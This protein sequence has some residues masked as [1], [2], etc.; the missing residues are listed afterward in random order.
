M[1]PEA[2]QHLSRLLAEAGRRI[3]A[4]YRKGQTEHGGFL[5]GY[6]PVE[7]IEFALD[8]AIDQVVYL[9]TLR[10]VFPAQRNAE[11]GEAYRTVGNGAKS[12]TYRYD[13]SNGRPIPV[14]V[15]TFPEQ[16]CHCHIGAK[17]V[18]K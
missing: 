10:E 18:C 1:K 3:D 15:S 14:E 9:L 2:E 17:H 12:G 13:W 16:D 6:A 7:L 11:C 4:K 5:P 8:E